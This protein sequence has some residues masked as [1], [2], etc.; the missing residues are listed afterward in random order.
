M[1]GGGG[2]PHTLT[3][4]CPSIPSR[5]LIKLHSGIQ[6]GG[7]GRAGGYVPPA[8][9]PLS[10]KKAQTNYEIVPQCVCVLTLL[11]TIYATIQSPRTIL[12]RLGLTRCAISQNCPGTPGFAPFAREWETQRTF[13]QGMENCRRACDRLVVCFVYV[14]LCLPHS[15]VFAHTQSLITRSHS[16]AMSHH[17]ATQTPI[18]I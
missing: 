13:R 4:L 2:F 18:M 16:V 11:A 17:L 9:L 15:I 6:R 12:V 14:Y 10:G 8:P 1:Y 3:K 7:G 5:G